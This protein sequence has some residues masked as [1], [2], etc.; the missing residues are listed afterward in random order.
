[1]QLNGLRSSNDTYISRR[2]IASCA[3]WDSFSVWRPPQSLC[4]CFFNTGSSAFKMSKNASTHAFRIEATDDLGLFDLSAFF[5]STNSAGHDWTSFWGCSLTLLS[6]PVSTETVIRGIPISFILSAAW[7]R[8]VTQPSANCGRFSASVAIVVR[9]TT[10]TASGSCFSLAGLPCCSKHALHFS[11]TRC[12]S[13]MPGKWLLLY[14][15]G[16]ALPVHIHLEIRP[17][18]QLVGPKSS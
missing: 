5:R 12:N 4:S 11:V 16:L 8:A 2:F 17:L 1:M 3:C 9:T 18:S 15:F 14:G 7:T 10:C 6:Y 13:E